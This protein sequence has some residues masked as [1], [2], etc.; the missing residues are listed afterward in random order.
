M[1]ESLKTSSPSVIELL[2]NSEAN[3]EHHREI[4]DYLR[5]KM[6]RGRKE[7]E[8]CYFAKEK[9]KEKIRF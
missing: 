4:E 1:D 9:I 2:T 7:K 6:M 3:F 5:K 8:L